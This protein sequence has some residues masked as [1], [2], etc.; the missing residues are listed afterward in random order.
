MKSTP[1]FVAQVT[2]EETRPGGRPRPPKPRRRSRRP[3]SRPPHRA[4]RFGPRAGAVPT[5]TKLTLAP[6]G[7]RGWRRRG[8]PSRFTASASRSPSTKRTRCGTPTCI[9]V[10]VGG[11]PS[12]HGDRIARKREGGKMQRD[13]LPF[14]DRRDRAEAGLQHG[15]VAADEPPR[16]RVP[17]RASRPVRAEGRRPAVGVVVV[18]AHAVRFASRKQQDAV[19]S[20]R[21][22][23]P[24]DQRE[25]A[26]VFRREPPAVRL[27][28][29]EVVTAAR[30]LDETLGHAMERRSL[31]L[32]S[33]RFGG[34]LRRRGAAVAGAC[35]LR[36]RNSGSAAAAGRLVR[37]DRVREGSLRQAR[38]RAPSPSARKTRYPRDPARR[39]GSQ[40]SAD[41]ARLRAARPP[42][43]GPAAGRR[44]V[45]DARF[46]GRETLD[47]GVLFD[48]LPGRCRR[49]ARRRARPCPRTTSR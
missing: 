22:T 3:A 19:R 13:L 46:L 9:G 43:P 10:P 27:E 14:H 49:A 30:H 39:T 41:Q 40:R 25:T 31:A 45:G 16:D 24:A 6:S 34:G 8:G 26:L 37:E 38:R 1:L 28:Q 29:D 32:T 4:H 11:R 20:D 5:R 21:E 15:R 36:R 2:G 35:P 44:R 7:I 23:A 33:E 48:A 12:A 42:A 18:Q 17:R 47:L